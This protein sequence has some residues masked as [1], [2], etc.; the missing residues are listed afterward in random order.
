[1][2]DEGG[3]VWEGKRDGYDSL[4]ALLDEAEKT[5]KEWMDSNW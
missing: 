3:M 2:V 1:M 4:E 5:I